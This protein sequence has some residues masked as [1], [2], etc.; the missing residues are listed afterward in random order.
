MFWR[1]S[2]GGRQGP[3]QSDVHDYA[4]S[5][6]NRKMILR[7]MLHIE[8]LERLLAHNNTIS[9]IKILFDRHL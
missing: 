7:K 5:L 1:V 8:A 6:V 9:P 3:A 2:V 4:A